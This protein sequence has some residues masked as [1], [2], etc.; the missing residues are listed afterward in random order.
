MATAAAIPLP[1]DTAGYGE[2]WSLKT[3]QEISC[4]K[5]AN[6]LQSILNAAFHER[7]WSTKYKSFGSL[8]YTVYKEMAQQHYF[9]DI[10]D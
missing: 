7:I 8:K 9:M 5:R 10:R 6:L 4:H 3:Q 2:N 1:E